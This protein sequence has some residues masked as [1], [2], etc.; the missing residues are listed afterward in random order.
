[1]LDVTE[2]LS[3]K[4]EN[5]PDQTVIRCWLKADILPREH[6]NA[7]K[8][9]DTRLDRED[10]EDTAITDHLCDMVAKIT[11]PASVTDAR[12]MPRVL[13][14]NLFVGKQ[15]GLTDMQKGVRR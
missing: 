11:M 3:Q 4:W 6:V 9:K 7:L 2:I 14:D 1:M 15:P 8:G 12:S 13:T 10:K 5:F